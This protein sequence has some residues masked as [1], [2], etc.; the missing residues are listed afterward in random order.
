[1]GLST[2]SLGTGSLA[3]VAFAAFGGPLA[4]AAL[5]APG[6]IDEVTGS[7]GLVVVAAAVAFI[8]P[9]AIWLRYSRDIASAGGLAAF[10][11]AA[12]GR[13]VA[14]AQAAVWVASY[15]LYL[16]YTGAYVAYDVLPSSISGVHKWRPLIAVLIPLG[17]AAA[18]AAGRGVSVAVI[19]LLAVGQ[20]A[21]LVMLDVVAVGHAGT[22]NG[23]HGTTSG[24]GGKAVA[25]VAALF[26]CGSL[27]LFLGGELR[28]RGRA[29]RRVLPLAFVLT[30]VGVLLAIYPYARDPAFTRADV[31]GVALVRVDVG[32]T[33]A[34]VVGIGVAGSIVAVL[35]LEGVALTRL[36]HFATGA[37]VRTWTWVLAGALVVIGPLSLAFDPDRFYD[38][39]LKPSL[40]LLWIA[41][42][43]VVAVFPVYVHRRAQLRPWHLLATAVALALMTYA[44]VTT[45]TGGGG[46]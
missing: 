24:D 14:L 25:A 4:L 33:A 16:L 34:D 9:L 38:S 15:G 39:L 44:L 35:L 8:A 26:V 7:G 6:A 28:E 19:G 43:V 30:A 40:V 31:P 37:T 23:F 29:L 3:L 1:M 32:H 46:T 18:L 20:F 5:Y 21:I 41:Q 42:L 22:A 27:P 45:I 17:V 10:V 36:L 2:R 12:A 11:E 13:G